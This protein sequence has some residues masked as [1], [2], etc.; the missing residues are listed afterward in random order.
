M[1]CKHRLY[2]ARILGCFVQRVRGSIL[3][4]IIF[5]YIIIYSSLFLYSY[6]SL[7]NITSIVHYDLFKYKKYWISKIIFIQ[8]LTVNVISC[9]LNKCINSLKIYLLVG[10][11]LLYPF[12]F[13]LVFSYSVG[14]CLRH[15]LDSTIPAHKRCAAHLFSS[16]ICSNF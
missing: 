3:Y 4:I 14:S 11:G 1:L 9:F 16:Q 8:A 2:V 12:S 13:Q 6:F 10:K 5:Y 15:L 7:T